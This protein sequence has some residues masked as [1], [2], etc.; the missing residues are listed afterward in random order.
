[1]LNRFFRTSQVQN[2]SNCDSDELKWKAKSSCSK[3][4]RFDQV[5]YIIGCEYCMLLTS[6]PEQGFISFLQ[7]LTYVHV[8]GF[9]DALLA[10][11]VSFKEPYLGEEES[12]DGPL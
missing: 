1:M 3:S 6:S 10:K 7:N 11:N 2:D 5:D 9:S 8:V 4:W 12:N